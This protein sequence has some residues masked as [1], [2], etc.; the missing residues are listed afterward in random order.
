MAAQ[1]SRIPAV[2]SDSGFLG[3]M[4]DLRKLYAGRILKPMSEEFLGSSKGTW[5]NR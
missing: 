3:Y 4:M 1:E 2:I 5:G